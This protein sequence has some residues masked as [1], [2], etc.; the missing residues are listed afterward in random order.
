M[1][2][3][4]RRM[5]TYALLVGALPLLTIACPFIFLKLDVKNDTFFTLNEFNLSSTSSSD[6]GDNLLEG[7]KIERGEKWTI[8]HIDPGTYDHRGVFWTKDSGTIEVF[9]LSNPVTFDTLNI[10]L[11]YQQY[12]DTDSIATILMDVL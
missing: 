5:L 9:N 6:W 4:A 3:R 2:R 11:T 8:S 12:V 7:N 10:C 1:S